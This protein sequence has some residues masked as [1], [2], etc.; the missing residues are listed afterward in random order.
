[1]FAEFQ[2]YFT[3]LSLVKILCMKLKRVGVCV[4][5]SQQTTRKYHFARDV[6]FLDVTIKSITEFVQLIVHFQ[7]FQQNKQ[8][9]H[10]HSLINVKRHPL[11]HESKKRKKNGK[12]SNRD[13]LHTQHIYINQSA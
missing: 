13:P 9:I 3:F 4:V 5:K 2:Q 12:N 11:I 6:S 7:T 1:M 8:I 10:R